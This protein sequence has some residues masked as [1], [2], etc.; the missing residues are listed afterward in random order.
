[1]PASPTGGMCGHC[2]RSDDTAG[3]AAPRRFLVGGSRHRSDPVWALA[4]KTIGGRNMRIVVLK[5]PGFITKVVKLFSR[6]K[7]T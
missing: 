4:F 6:K 5:M 1:M 2:C 3:T 7:D